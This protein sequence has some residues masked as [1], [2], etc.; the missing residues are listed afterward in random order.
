MP[1][2][3]RYIKQILLAYDRGGHKATS[4]MDNERSPAASSGPSAVG[5]ETSTGR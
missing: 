4:R 3:R 5:A 1:L 2:P